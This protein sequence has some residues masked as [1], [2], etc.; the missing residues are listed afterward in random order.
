MSFWW[1]EERVQEVH[2]LDMIKLYESRQEDLNESTV[3][4]ETL[5][6]FHALLAVS[7]FLGNENGCV[8]NYLISKYRRGEMKEK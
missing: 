5:R 3:M 6:L 4:M 7:H 2:Y 1:K 8:L